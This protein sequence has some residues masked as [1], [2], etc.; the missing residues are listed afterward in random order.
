MEL[1]AQRNELAIDGVAIDGNDFLGANFIHIG[2]RLRLFGLI[3]D[4]VDVV[5]VVEV[6]NIKLIFDLIP[7]LLSLLLPVGLKLKRNL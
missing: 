1:L 6:A 4:V 2:F 5:D 7:L 3:F